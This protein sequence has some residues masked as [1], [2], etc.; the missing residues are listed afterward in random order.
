[1]EV[2]IRIHALRNRRFTHGQHAQLDADRIERLLQP[3]VVLFVLVWSLLLLSEHQDVIAD[4]KV[5][6]V[7][8]LEQRQVV[9]GK[10]GTGGTVGG[11]W[12]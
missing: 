2:I 4:E 10:F 6:C 12:S 11:F 5:I 8:F 3:R 7:T 9:I 1:M